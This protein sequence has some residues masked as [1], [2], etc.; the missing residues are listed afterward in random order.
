[1]AG[2]SIAISLVLALALLLSACADRPYRWAKEGA[3]AGEFAA[4]REICLD[5]VER[6]YS[7]F[8]DYCSP[9]GRGCSASERMMGQAIRQQELFDG[10]IQERGFRRVPQ[11]V[12][13]SRL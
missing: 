13:P 8:E 12:A 4:A 7:E 9:I 5:V 10:C 1:M 6:D 3:G 11:T 2:Y